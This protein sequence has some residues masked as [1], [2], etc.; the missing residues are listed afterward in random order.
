MKIIIDQDRTNNIIKD[1]RERIQAINEESIN[2]IVPSLHTAV[3]PKI[4][5]RC[6]KTFWESAKS[7]NIFCGKSDC[8][9][10]EEKTDAI[11]I[12]F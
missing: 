9:K 8:H 1:A 3:I 6:R 2:P 12:G 7:A 11:G 10:D 5:D 4:C